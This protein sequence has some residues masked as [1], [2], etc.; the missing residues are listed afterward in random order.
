MNNTEHT[1]VSSIEELRAY[2]ITEISAA[3]GVFDGVHAG[4]RKLLAT[5][6]EVSAGTNSTP[7]A[8]TFHPHPR[9]LID[10]ENAPHLL[11]SQAEKRSRLFE[12]GVK[13]VVTLPFTCD[14]AALEP[15][16]F[17]KQ[18]LMASGISLRGLCVGEHWRFGAKGWGNTA[19]LE[20]FSAKY[21]FEFRAVPELSLDGETVSSSSIRAA[22]QGGDLTKAEKFLGR[23]SMLYGGV[24]HGA[25]IAG[26]VLTRPTA[27]IELE[28]GILPPNGVYAVRVH[29]D[30]G[31]WHPGIANIG[32][33]PTFRNDD[34]ILIE[35]HLLD[36]NADLYGHRVSLALAA[37]IRPEIKFD[38]AEQL[39]AQIAED[40]EK[41][42]EVL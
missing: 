28:S 33:A 12:T 15:E 30:D 3:V 32:T 24:V 38:T 6:Q 1:A 26:K 14:L 25:G 4:H 37:R 19:L 7:V 9:Q 42:F 10:P 36:G 2:G 21:G 17:L 27:N 22:I 34:R 11:L 35:A 29:T 20:T 13:A 5:L 41:A 16:D 8:V 18:Q 39:R 40:I 23:P 31:I